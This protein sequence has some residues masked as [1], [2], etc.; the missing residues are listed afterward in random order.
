MQFVDLQRQ[1]QQHKAE[2]DRAIQEVLDSS[3]Y[4]MGPQIQELEKVL[5]EFVGQESCI[6]CG[7]GTDAIQLA[8]MALDI[9]P[10]DEVIT[11]PFTFVA[12]AG[13]IRLV[14]ATPVFV[15]IEDETFNIDIDQIEEAI[16][17]KTKAIMPV[18]LFGQMTDYDRING[19]GL[20]VIEDGAQSF[21]ASRDGKMSC[22]V[23]TLA[24]TSFYPAKPFG[25]YG[26]GGAIFTSDRELDER[27]RAM[28]VHGGPDYAHVGMNG[29]FDTI[30]AAILLAKWPHYQG[31]LEKR[32]QLAARY[33]RE[34]SE[35][36][37]TPK[38]AEGNSHT[39][40]AYTIR[41]QDRDEFVRQLTV[42]THV[43]Y[44]K[45]LHQQPAFE[46]GTFP[47]AEAAARE[48]VSL[49][50]HPWLTDDEQTQIIEAVQ[51]LCSALV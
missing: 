47:V 46:G 22:G 4:L 38:V 29:R 36:C 17:P 6:T 9:G 11:T 30:Q 12:T 21:G 1:Y 51:N 34:L 14:G 8:L 31:E 15:D 41:I 37:Q 23:T 35:C 10:G 40:A 50:I 28:R 42:P 43:Y 7:S 39:Y 49:P 45:C 25:C 48:V 27:M 32:R 3:R 13:A 18:S 44:P 16:T 20:R 33:D 19:F 2:I 26:D 24:T 5:A